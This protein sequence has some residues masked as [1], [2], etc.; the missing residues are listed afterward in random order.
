MPG[1][2]T[3]FARYVSRNKDGNGKAYNIYQNKS[4]ERGYFLDGLKVS[5]TMDNKWL[6]PQKRK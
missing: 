6:G 5:I 4:T 3:A 2:V 1:S